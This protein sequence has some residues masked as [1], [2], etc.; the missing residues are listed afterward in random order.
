M[1]SPNGKL[2]KL[3]IAFAQS[4][5]DASGENG[6]QG[7]PRWVPL[8]SPV[9]FLDK[10]AER[11]ENAVHVEQQGGRAVAEVGFPLLPGEGAVKHPLPCLTPMPTISEYFD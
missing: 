6:Q 10:A 8:G 11:A 4:N 2:I 5:T 9:G 7:V 3:G 1:S